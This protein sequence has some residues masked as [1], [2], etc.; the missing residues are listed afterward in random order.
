MC[1]NSERSPAPHNQNRQINGTM[2]TDTTKN[3]SSSLRGS[4]RFEFD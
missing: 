1:S 3:Q 2:K 4:D